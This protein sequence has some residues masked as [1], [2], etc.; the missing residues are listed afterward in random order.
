MSGELEFVFIFEFLNDE[1]DILNFIKNMNK[2]DYNIINGMISN[3]CCYYI[4]FYYY[5]KGKRQG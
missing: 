4:A 1:F 2:I 5:Y 3:N